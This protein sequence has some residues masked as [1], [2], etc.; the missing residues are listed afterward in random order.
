MGLE[1]REILSKSCKETPFLSAPFR[2]LETTAL[3]EF[4]NVL[5][6]D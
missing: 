5:L 6:S 2:G 4:Q 1:L 3:V